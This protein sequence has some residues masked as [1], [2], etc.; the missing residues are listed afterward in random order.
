MCVSGG[1]NPAVHL[2]SQARGKLRY[3]EAL[4]T[5]VPDA[6]PLPIIA[7]GCRQR[8]L[9]SGA[10]LA[11][12][13]PPAPQRERAGIA[14]VRL[15]PP[16]SDCTVAVA[17]LWSRARAQQVGKRFV[18][19]QND[20]TVDDIALAAREGYQSVEHLKRYTTLGMGT[21]QGK[22]SN[23]IGL[24]LLARA[25]RT[26]RSRG[27]HDDVPPAVHAG[28]ARRDSRPR[29][30]A[31]TSS[32]R[33]TRRCTTGTPRTARASSTPGCGSAR[34]RIRAPARSE[35]DAA[36]REARNVRT[37]VGVVDVST[38]GKI[39][40]QGRDV[41]EFLEPRLH[42]HAGTRSRSAAA[43]TA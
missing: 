17:P 14:S 8:L 13:M 4:A 41:A 42:Q 43:A 20:V 25:A 3:D 22:T 36:N 18:D 32:R 29:S 16:P 38:L 35:D 24:A 1:W 11:T 10:A 6:S 5:F 37:N 34:I 26:S 21:D 7:G 15:A 12:A 19:L 9:R 2:F 40:L 33:A 23:I 28:H 27:R 39:E 30:R 31:R